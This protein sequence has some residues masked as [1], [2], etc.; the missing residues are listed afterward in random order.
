MAASIAYWGA[1][2]SGSPALNLIKSLGKVQNPPIKAPIRVFKISP[3]DQKRLGNF[4]K[5]IFR[6]VVTHNTDRFNMNTKNTNF[7]VFNVG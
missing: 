3:I 6:E 7:N 2:T 1:S 4:P 5:K